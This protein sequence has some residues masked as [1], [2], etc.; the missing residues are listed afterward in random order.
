VDPNAKFV[1][2]S[3]DDANDAGARIER[4]RSRIA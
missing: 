4:I 2:P 3:G 1:S